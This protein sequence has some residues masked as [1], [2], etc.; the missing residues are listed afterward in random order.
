MTGDKKIF[1][2]RK[3][4]STNLSITITEVISDTIPT[5]H[6]KKEPERYIEALMRISDLTMKEN[7]EAMRNL[8]LE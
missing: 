5:H 7:K 4:V 1:L 6:I 3:S 2:L 8:N